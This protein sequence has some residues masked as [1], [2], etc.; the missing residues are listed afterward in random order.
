MASE[1]YLHTFDNL[2]NGITDVRLSFTIKPFE[3]YTNAY[4][5]DDTL[6]L[7]FEGTNVAPWTVD[8]GTLPL[9]YPGTGITFHMD[10]SDLPASGSSDLNAMLS[11]APGSGVNT[12]IGA[13]EAYDFID[14]VIEDQQSV[15]SVSLIICTEENGIIQDDL[16][17][18]CTK[19]GATTPTGGTY[20][21]ETHMAG[22][23]DLY[24][25]NFM[26]PA[27]APSQAQMDFMYA[28]VGM[29]LQVNTDYHAA[30]RWRM[31]D[32]RNLVGP[33]EVIT[34][35][36]VHVGLD[37]VS[38]MVETDGLMFTFLE[39]DA[40]GNWLTTTNSNGVTVG[41]GIGVVDQDLWNPA[42]TQNTM[43]NRD[44]HI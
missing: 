8:L 42:A 3:Y 30:N 6:S 16:P 44:A 2:P 26:D 4:S 23:S 11:M 29:N 24:N 41:Q 12:V 25:Q 33:N 40:N 38:G 7:R 9:Q 36:S 34:H 14:V 37:Y 22:L 43:S 28:Q 27:L 5:I 18:N 15:D 31:H 39:E 19:P 10:L 20:I 1:Y 21:V 32:F 17:L 13:M 35:A